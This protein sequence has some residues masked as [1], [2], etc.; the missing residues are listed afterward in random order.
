MY[1][2]CMPPQLSGTG[3]VVVKHEGNIPQQGVEGL[4]V[5]LSLTNLQ[6]PGEIFLQQPVNGEV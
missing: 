5:V 6:G 1:I 4:V 3:G 2:R